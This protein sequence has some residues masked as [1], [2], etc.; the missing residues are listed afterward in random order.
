MA[1]AAPMPY[2]GSRDKGTAI[3]LMREG[4]AWSVLGVIWEAI[5]DEKTAFSTALCF[6]FRRRGWF[7][8]Y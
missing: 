5:R 8:L 4:M 7:A 6:W 2:A 1:C 3:E